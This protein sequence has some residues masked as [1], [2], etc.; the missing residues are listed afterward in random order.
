MVQ[1]I[2]PGVQRQS[3]MQRLGAG[4]VPG[5][6]MAKQVMGDLEQKQ[7]MKHQQQVIA[8]QF[9]ELAG[10][11][12]EMQKVGFAEKMKQQ[13]KQ[14]MLQQKQDYLS[15]LFGGQGQGQQQG[16]GD[17]LSQVGQLQQ[18]GQGNGQG[19]DPTKLTDEDIA[20]A[21][22]MDPNLGRALGHAK[23]VALRE[24]S[25][26]EKRSF[27]R[28]KFEYGKISEKEKMARSEAEA[29][30]K[31]LMLELQQAR[32]NIPLQEQAI[33][34]IKMASPEVGARDYLADVTGFEPLR[35]AEGAKLK[36]AIKDYFL[37][38][39]TRVGARPNQWVEQQL[40]DALPK[41]G[42]STEAN[43]ITAEGLKFKLDLAKKRV[44]I[45]DELAAKDTEKHGYVKSDI[46]SRASKLLKPVVEQQKKE[47]IDNIT[48]IKKKY[49]SLGKEEKAGKYITIMS[50]QGELL[51]IL[52]SDLKEAEEHGYIRR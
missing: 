19:L 7:L 12:P 14:S 35:T 4:I 31:P 28:E 6:E 22:A 17:E 20:R 13:G 8:Q 26:G 50:P 47:I 33:E 49:K 30:T 2:G 45:I 24:R 44:D 48:A 18:G 15:Q 36:T 41:I 51:E 27:E 39:L 23:D 25:S 46:D 29:I 10:L 42:R 1:V 34:D 32:K 40:L 9:P 43:L 11:S 16:M 52:P 5:L 37:S 21:T 38:D 3:F